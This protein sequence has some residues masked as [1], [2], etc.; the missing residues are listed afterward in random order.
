[1]ANPDNQT[2]EP[3]PARRALDTLANMSEDA[4]GTLMDL[5]DESE[6]L[7]NTV[8]QVICSIAHAQGALELTVYER[9]LS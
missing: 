7:R 2:R 9:R 1:M 8:Y 5:H 3:H 6:L 4:Y